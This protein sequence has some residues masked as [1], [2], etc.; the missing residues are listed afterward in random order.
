[1]I[2]LAGAGAGRRGAPVGVA[3]RSVI[4]PSSGP[5]IPSMH[6]WREPF[7]GRRGLDSKRV[8]IVDDQESM[9]EMLADLL[10]MM[11]H[12]PEAVEGGEQALVRLEES[13]IDL[14]ITDLNM[15]KMD[16]MELMKRIKD[17]M[18]AMPVIVITGYGTFHTEKQ[19]LSNGADGY[20]PKPCTIHRV[21]ETVTAALEVQ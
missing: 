3:D 10:D 15:P 1:M 12:E 17:Q 18:P 16:G 4:H 21:Q 19:V 6:D 2:L 11:G 8:L 13:G 9:R 7:P 14:V 20:I 5:P